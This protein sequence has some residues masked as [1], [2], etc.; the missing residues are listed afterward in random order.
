MHIG[1]TKIISKKEIEFK[2]NDRD[3]NISYSDF[4]NL[5]RELY[6]CVIT[7]MKIMLIIVYQFGTSNHAV[8]NG[9]TH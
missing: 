9:Q 6:A 5:V 7:L 4:I 2:S 8:T 3:K 1:A